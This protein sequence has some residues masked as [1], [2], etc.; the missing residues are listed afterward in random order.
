MQAETKANIERF[1][2]VHLSRAY[3]SFRDGKEAQL[4]L[5]GI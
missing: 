2:F 4:Q 5:V 3:Q 1:N